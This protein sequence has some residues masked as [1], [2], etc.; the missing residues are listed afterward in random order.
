MS[1]VHAL[2]R[3]IVDGRLTEG[4]RINEVRLAELLGVSRTPLREALN[5][6][7]TEGA[8]TARPGHGWF[9][10][11]LTVEEFEQLYDIR[12]L[13]DPH[14]LRIAGPPAPD[15]LKRLEKLNR[16]LEPVAD[17]EAAIDGDD[18]WHLELLAHCPNRVLVELIETMMLRTRRYELALMR[19]AG[20]VVRATTHHKQILTALRRGNLEKACAVLKANMQ[21]GKAPILEWLAQRPT[22][23]AHAKLKGVKT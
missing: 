1:A 9:V 16:D 13:L 2:R 6:L 11:P 15:R 8:L 12:P 19:E 4:E 21:H 17:A 10:R 14:A 23:D 18:A 5:R 20:H 22:A 3:M 7:A